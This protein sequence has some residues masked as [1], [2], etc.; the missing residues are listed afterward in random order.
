[1]VWDNKDKRKEKVFDKRKSVVVSRLLRTAGG[2]ECDLAMTA[3]LPEPSI[4]CGN[5][6]P[7]HPVHFN[8]PYVYLNYPSIFI[9][10]FYNQ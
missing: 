6:F 1:M 9:I 2:S 5:Y 8:E 4:I 7:R 3:A 10:S